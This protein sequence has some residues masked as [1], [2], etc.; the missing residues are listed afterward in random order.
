MVDVQ[1]TFTIWLVL[2]TLTLQT[3][4]R[5][6][7]VQPTTTTYVQPT[8]RRT[9]ETIPTIGLIFTIIHLV[10]CFFLGYFP[11]LVCL[12]PALICAIVVSIFTTLM[13]TSVNGGGAEGGSHT[14][15]FYETVLIHEWGRQLVLSVATLVHLTCK[16]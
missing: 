8:Q 3:T 9:N 6:I 5:V 4:I 2:S 15:Y 7:A 12:A 1:Y 13:H 11:I 16:G 14:F 10:G